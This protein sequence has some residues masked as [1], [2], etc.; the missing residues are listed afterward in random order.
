[1]DAWYSAPKSATS[2]RR[3]QMFSI[4]GNTCATQ[5][6]SS[7]QPG[8]RG[9]NF[10]KTVGRTVISRFVGIEKGFQTS[11]VILVILDQGRDQHRVST[12]A[13]KRFVRG[14]PRRARLGSARRFLDRCSS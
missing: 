7:R 3:S 1:M 14:S 9:V 11:L 12:K 2:V 8:Y 5:A 4:K 13:L 6:V 10:G